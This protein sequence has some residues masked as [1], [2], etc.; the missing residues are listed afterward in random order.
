M[1]IK[2]LHTS[3]NEGYA[4]KSDTNK[5]IQVRETQRKRWQASLGDKNYETLKV[6]I[7]VQ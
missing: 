5:R 1:K 3:L 7:A 2:Y 6:R 4:V